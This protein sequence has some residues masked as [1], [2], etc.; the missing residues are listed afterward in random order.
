MKY[1]Y[2]IIIIAMIVIGSGQIYGTST[3]INHNSTTI[4]LI[5]TDDCTT[6]IDSFQLVYKNSIQALIKEYRAFSK[7]NE[8]AKADSV[9]HEVDLIYIHFKKRFNHT[10]P[11]YD[12]SYLEKFFYPY[13]A[14][15]FYIHA[16]KRPA[17]FDEMKTIIETCE[18]AQEEESFLFM[19]N[20]KAIYHLRMNEYTQ[21]KELLERGLKV[22]ESDV[23]KHLQKT[24]LL[25]NNYIIYFMFMNLREQALVEALKND[26][27]FEK[28]GIPNLG[29]FIKNL[30][31][32]AESYISLDMPEELNKTLERLKFYCETEATLKDNENC[33][34]EEFYFISAVKNRQFLSADSILNSGFKEKISPESYDI[35]MSLVRL[36]LALNRYDEAEAVIEDLKATFDHYKV[37]ETHQY[38]LNLLKLQLELETAKDKTLTNTKS[39]KE[40]EYA[41]LANVYNVFNEAPH[42]QFGIIKPMRSLA[43]NLLN[44]FWASENQEIKQIVYN[45]NTNIK[46]LTPSFLKKRNAILSALDAENDIKESENLRADLAQRFAKAQK[47]PLADHLIKQQLM[48]SI[49]LVEKSIQ[50]AFVKNLK[51]TIPSVSASLIQKQ[52]KNDELFLE[53]LQD[54]NRESKDSS[55]YMVVI[56]NQNFEIKKIDDRAMTISDKINFTNDS[57]YNQRWYAYFFGSIS[58]LLQGKKEIFVVSDGVINRCPLEILSPDGTRKNCL[59]NNCEFTYF[60]SSKSF[61]EQASDQNEIQ[62]I[63]AI[64]GIQYDCTTDPRNQQHQLALRK[65]GDDLVYLPGTLTEVKKIK[66]RYSGEVALLTGCEATKANFLTQINDTTFSTIHISTHGIIYKDTIF[67]EQDYLYLHAGNKAFLALANGINGYLSAYEITNQN[68][69]HVKL[70]YLS[71]CSSGLGPQM[72][73]NGLFSIGEAFY[74]AGADKVIYSLWDISDDFAVKFTDKFYENLQLSASITTAFHKTQKYFSNN[75]P[76]VLW[77]SFRLME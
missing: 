72:V 14:F 35:K 67:S 25:R 34:L 33:I 69:Q 29:H 70:A 48:D 52:L 8:N 44:Q 7:N 13:A 40:I 41:F 18:A 16:E 1:N 59:I 11:T 32:M 65:G 57:E 22:A 3:D 38:R 31:F 64:G 46:K 10:C 24:S 20:M 63:L 53:F 26:Q 2:W 23:E 42:Q 12:I 51:Y 56:S 45:L 15:S 9:I 60:N 68:L 62:K 36:H 5:Q 21:M 47:S 58:H 49:I 27:M 61:L 75:Y 76:P 4:P 6:L 66:D 73:G 74:G 17:L 39:L 28:Y 71:A 50:S 55:L 77:S 37:E 43:W 19:V 54:N 30:C